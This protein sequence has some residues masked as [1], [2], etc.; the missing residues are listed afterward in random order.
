[1]PVRLEHVALVWVARHKMPE[2]DVVQVLGMFVAAARTPVEQEEPH[3][4]GLRMTAAVER[5]VIEAM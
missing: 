3:T 4:A 1:M 2:V 5:T